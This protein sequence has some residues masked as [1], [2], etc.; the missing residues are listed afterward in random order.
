MTSHEFTFDYRFGFPLSRV[1]L[2]LFY[3]VSVEF[4]RAEACG[5]FTKFSLGYSVLKSLAP[6]RSILFR[7]AGQWT[8]DRLTSLEQFNLGGV[9]QFGERFGLHLMDPLAA[10]SAACPVRR[11]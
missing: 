9:N 7:F 1:L 8:D 11:R 2:D 10:G 3:K 6:T 5:D 4:E